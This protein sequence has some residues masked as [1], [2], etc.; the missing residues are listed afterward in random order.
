MIGSKTSV[1]APPVDL[2]RRLFEACEDFSSDFSGYAAGSVRTKLLGWARNQTT[3][4]GGGRGRVAAETR[5]DCVVHRL[6]ISLCR[7]SYCIAPLDR[8]SNRSWRAM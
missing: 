8:E 2:L 4:L 1:H 5:Q 7:Q 3:L 6:V